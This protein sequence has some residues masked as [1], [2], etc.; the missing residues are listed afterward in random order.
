MEL[1]AT[2]TGMSDV[3]KCFTFLFE[4]DVLGFGGSVFVG[5]SGFH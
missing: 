2:L 4:F 1:I 3:R 5:V